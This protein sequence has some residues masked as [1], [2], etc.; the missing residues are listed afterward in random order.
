[1]LGGEKDAVAYYGDHRPASVY[2]D[3][4][5]VTTPDS[6]TYSGAAL[7]MTDTYNDGAEVSFEGESSQNQ[8]YA[9]DF[10]QLVKDPSTW[11]I[12][13]YGTPYGTVT[14]EDGVAQHIRLRRKDIRHSTPHTQ[15]RA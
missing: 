12:P 11:Y 9:V 13:S 15:S 8:G 5:T 7:T 2:V 14:V 10:N 6:V 4:D 3:G 1:M